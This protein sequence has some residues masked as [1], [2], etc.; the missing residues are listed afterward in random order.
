MEIGKPQEIPDILIE[1][2][3]SPVPK[4]EPTPQPEPIK[5][6]EPVKVPA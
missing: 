2:V 6:P 4:K 1:P 5:K 3:R